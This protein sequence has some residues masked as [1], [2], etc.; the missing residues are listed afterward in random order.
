MASIAPYTSVL[1][2]RHA[3]H[4]LRRTTFNLSKSIIDTC[5]LS[6]A[7]D[8]LED[9]FAVNSLN[10]PEP[11][12]VQTLEHF[13]NLGIEPTSN[14]SNQKS[15]V[16]SWWME[17]ALNDST[18][19]H[20]LE[21]FLHS[22]FIT[23]NSI[24]QARETYDYLNLFRLSSTRYTNGSFEMDSYKSLALKMITDNA[25]L[26]YLNGR[27]NTSTSPNENFAR[28][29]FELFTIGKG[30]QIGVG[31]YTTYTEDD[32]VEGAKLLTGWI[33]RTR[34][35]G[36]GG[37]PNY[38]DPDTQIQRGD[39][40]YSKH[41]TTDKHFS[42]AFNSR[43]I[44]GAVDEEDMWRELSDYVNMIFDSDATAINIA[45]KIYRYFVSSKISTE[46]ET[47]IIAPLAD[48]LIN[49]DYKISLAIKQL[50]KSEH[51]YDM[52]D[53]NS[54]DE[55]IGSVL[56]SP[57]EMLTQ[58]MSF[59]E[60][61]RPNY[62]TDADDHYNRWYRNTVRYVITSMAGMPIFYPDSV[63]GYPAYYQEPGYSR[64]WFNGATLIARYKQPEILLTGNRILLSGNNG[65]VQLDFVKYVKKSLV[66]S[67]PY[68][69]QALVDDLIY[70]LFPEPPLADRVQYFLDIFL[71]GLTQINWW[72]EWNKY[73]LTGDD[74][75]VK[76]PL[77][78]LFKA[79]LTSQEYGLK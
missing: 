51:F 32:I 37:D 47:D 8:A 59:F 48:T 33:N 70:Y 3:M 7:E 31:N 9:L 53:S 66:F 17:E 39:P 67:D 54:T 77:E 2:H 27:E 24:G 38:T 58:T 73:I 5:A 29:F 13:I 25:M 72:D 21:F 79:V 26:R 57:F 42:S 1:G 20:K 34:I 18:I 45:K 19:A 78:T 55:I 11:I 40:Q 74:S 46:I 43:I 76:L 69:S 4:L 50:L 10:L 61:E 49:N 22:I 14:T 56:K 71:D 36:A 65:G 12:D 68:D 44:T 52:D 6:T 16:L 28:E 41:D 75:N 15:Y 63:A 60:I 30:P 35:L 64:N 62:L 23:N